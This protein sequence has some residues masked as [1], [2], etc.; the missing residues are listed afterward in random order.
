MRPRSIFLLLATP[1]AGC[2][3]AATS[4]DA[5]DRAAAVREADCMRPSQITDWT[6]LDDRN[7]IVYEGRRPYHVEL[8][9]T[10]AGLDFATL[11][12]FYDRGVPDE[13]ICGDGKDRVVVDRLI[14][15]AC[16]I[17]AVDELTDEQATDLERRS[18]EQKA[19]ARPRP[20][21]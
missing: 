9:R 5:A 1:L 12:A 4:D 21:R 14:P 8:A 16:A 15:E 20:R 6:A 11:I 3:A 19:L 10:C 2:A 13:R 18:E 17:A 7:L